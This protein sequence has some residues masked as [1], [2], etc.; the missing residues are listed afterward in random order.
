MRVHLADLPAHKHPVSWRDHD[1]FILSLTDRKC[2]DWR[3]GTYSQ[4]LFPVRED[5]FVDWLHK[6][7]LEYL[8]QCWSAHLTPVVTPDIL[9]HLLLQEVALL[10][11]ESP[12]RYRSLFT[13][14][15]G[16]KADICVPSDDPAHLPIDLIIAELRSCVPSKVDLFLPAFST[17]TTRSSQAFMFTFADAVSPY[18]NYMTYACGLPAVEVRGTQEDYEELF[19]RWAEVRSLLETDRGEEAGWARQVQAQLGALV[20]RREDPE[21]WKQFFSMTKCGSGHEMEAYGW[22]TALYRV[23]PTGTRKVENFSSGLSRVSFTHIAT[24]QRFQLLSGL[25]S[26]ELRG[27]VLEPDFGYVVL[28]K[29]EGASA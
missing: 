23:Q 25:L 28:E 19:E 10:I 8:E 26:S 1:R 24:Q 27:E 5:L 2:V 13:L 29:R 4:S 17:S 12:G 15:Q 7:Y 9:W 20:S 6:G 16:G 11:G 3:T 21:H 14:A 22:V 18:Y